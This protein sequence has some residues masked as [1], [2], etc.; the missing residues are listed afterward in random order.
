MAN[1]SILFLL[2]CSCPMSS[3][4]LISTSELLSHCNL[5][6]EYVVILLFQVFQ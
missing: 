4:E 5:R 3:L 1:S 6:I 2:I